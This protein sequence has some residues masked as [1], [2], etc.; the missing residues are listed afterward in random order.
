[1]KQVVEFKDGGRLKITENGFKVY[2]VSGKCIEFGGDGFVIPAKEP[3]V[4]K[5]FCFM[6]REERIS[7][8]EWANKVSPLTK[9]QKRFVKVVKEAVAIVNYNYYIATIEPSFSKDNNIFY[10]KGEVISEWITTGDWVEKAE[11]MLASNGNWKSRLATLYELLM[12][13]AWRIAKGYWTFTYVCDD[14]SSNGNY[15]DSPTSS[16]ELEASGERSFAGFCDGTGNTVKIVTH[17][18][19]FALVGGNYKNDGKSYP[20]GDFYFDS[21]DY[22]LCKFGVGVV[23]IRRNIDI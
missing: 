11:V 9:S 6:G 18:D 22:R 10:E 17:N 5:Y 2:D 15:S 13:Y 4:L 20:V 23:T 14:S 8:K 7:V 16:F 1:M 19:G 3:E 21:L 12:W